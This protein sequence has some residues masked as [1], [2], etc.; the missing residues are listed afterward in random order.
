MAMPRPRLYA[1]PFGCVICQRRRGMSVEIY[2]DPIEIVGLHRS[3]TLLNPKPTAGI[4]T[5]ADTIFNTDEDLT[6]GFTTDDHRSVIVQNS[7]SLVAG[8]FQAWR[9]DPQSSHDTRP[10]MT[11]PEA[12][13]AK[14]LMDS[15]WLYFL[16]D[17][18][19]DPRTWQWTAK[20]SHHKRSD[21]D[22]SE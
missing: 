19:L 14:T 9:V 7:F 1:I 15:N 3:F 12:G 13:T 8:K 2:Y 10:E 17:S 4:K 11:K 22:D 6:L 5:L 20:K 18:A 16:L 21:S